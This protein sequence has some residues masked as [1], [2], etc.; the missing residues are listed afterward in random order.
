MEFLF[1]YI[2]NEGLNYIIFVN[3]N[4]IC[5]MFISQRGSYCF[6]LVLVIKHLCDISKGLIKK[7]YNIR[8]LH[9]ALHTQQKKKIKPNLKKNEK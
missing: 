4:N 6:W 5:I 2:C 1:Y 3:K 8:S 7:I 9:T